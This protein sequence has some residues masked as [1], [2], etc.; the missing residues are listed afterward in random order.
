MS[1]ILSQRWPRFFYRVIGVAALAT[2]GCQ[3]T[4]VD[5]SPGPARLRM[6]RP[7]RP[8]ESF[9]DS[10]TGGEVFAMYCN[11]CHNARYLGER[12]FFNY[13]NIA[14]H[15]RVRACMTGKEYEKLLEFLRRW[16]D[17]PSPTPPVEPSPK[18]LIFSQPIAELREEKPPEAQPAA[19]APAGQPAAAAPVPGPVPGAGAN[20]APLE[21]APMPA[22]A[23]GPNPAPPVAGPLPPQR[24][25]G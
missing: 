3:S 14:A 1:S 15:M 24:A 9:E 12:P 16:H 2:L 4:P 8:A 21:L 22:P 5:L 11:Q 10:L 7:G 25:G 17:V 20:P 13:E 23:A 19:A 6:P 18:R